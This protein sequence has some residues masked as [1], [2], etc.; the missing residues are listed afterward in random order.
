MV[1][2]SA[3]SGAGKTTVARHLLGIESLNLSFSISACSR[4]RRVNEVDGR[5]YYFLSED[6]FLEKVRADEFVEWE[7]VYPGRFYGTLRSEVERIWTLGRH[8]LFDIDVKG[9]MSIKR[10]YGNLA[11]SVFVMP[12]SL[13]ILEARLRSRSTDSTGDIRR[14]LEKA[15]EELTFAG[16]FDRVIINDRL[17][18]TLV[19]AGEAVRQFLEVSV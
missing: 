5:D 9:A 12:P 1:V 15:Q 16:Q 19:E 10:I 17:E 6:E 3:P 11:L 13:E 14:R 18:K 8:V 7:E 4:P 2:L